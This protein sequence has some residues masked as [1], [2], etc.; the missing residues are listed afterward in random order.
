MVSVP[1]H[2]KDCIISNDSHVDEQPLIGVVR[3]PCGGQTFHILYPGQ[4]H[5]HKGQQ[6][7][8]TAEI[9][10]NFFF[11]IKARCI[12][13]GKEHLLFDKDYHGWNGF[14]CH[15]YA[16]A[17]LPRPDLTPWQCLSCGGLEHEASI[18]IDPVDKAT[19][20]E[21]AGDEFDEELWPEAF[22]WFSMSITCHN[23]GRQ[24]KDWVSYET[25]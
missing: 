25:A 5:M 17:S 8:C 22:E 19:F 20:V 18:K 16:Q 14:V 7:P 24:T 1:N 23:C 4:T 21:E 3:C 11:L 13:C 12:S 6:I 9:D 10:G 15:N 2:L